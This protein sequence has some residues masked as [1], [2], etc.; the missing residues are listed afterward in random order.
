MAN[1][2]GL[3]ALLAAV[4]VAAH[5]DLVVQL[6]AGRIRGAEC[7]SS[8]A[9]HFQGIP[10][11]EPP[12]GKLRFM[13]PKPFKGSLGKGTFDA[14]KP[15]HPCIQWPSTYDVDDPTP[16]EDCLYLDVYVPA[17]VPSYGGLPV[18]V[19]AHG[20]GND[21]GS[22]SYPLYDSCHLA[23]DAIIV[24][25]QYRLGPL[26]FLGLASAGIQG[27]MAIQDYVA[28]LEWV[29]SNIHSFGGDPSK[30]VLFGQSS[31]ADDA[32]VVSTLP[33]I[34]SLVSGVILE[35]GGGQEMIN[36]AIV[37][38]TGASFAQ[39]LNCK[40][41][42]L[43]CL[44]SKS[45]VEL[46]EAYKKTPALLN[47]LENG[48]EL[49]SAFG[50]DLPNKTT[51]DAS[52]V[53]G[54]VIKQNPLKVGSKVPIIAGMAAAD[55]ALSVLPFF[56]GTGQITEANYTYF[57]DQFGVVGPAIGKQYPLSLFNSSGSTTYAVLAAISH[58][59]T[60]ATYQCSSSRALRAAVAAGTPAYA[61]RFNHTPSCPWL[62]NDGQ[63]FPGPQLASL[64][65]A[66][67][68]SELPF[69]FANLDNQPWGNGTCNATASER[70]LSYGLTSAW[71]AMA[72]KG[73]PSTSSKA[74]PKFDAQQTE[75]IYIQDSMKASKLD[76]SEC[77]FWDEIWAQLGG[78]S[79]P[80]HRRSL[81]NM[82]SPTKHFLQ[83]KHIV[84]AGGGLAGLAFSI[85]LVKQWPIQEAT[86]HITV[87]D[88]DSRY[89]SI[90]RQGYSLSMNGVDADGG[91]VA[92][93]QLG[94][95][96]QAIAKATPGTDEMSFKMWDGNWTELRTIKS[97]PYGSLP[98]GLLR[99]PRRDLREILVGAAE[100]L[101]IDMRWDAQCTTAKVLESGKVEISIL[102]NEKTEVSDKI[103]D[104]LI[105]ADGAQS[106]IRQSIRPDDVLQYAHAT[107]IGGVAKFTDGIPGPAKESWGILISGKGNSCFF[108]PLE[109]N[110]VIWAMSLVEDEPR[111]VPKEL[112]EN[113]VQGLIEE[114]LRH[115]G[116]IAEPFATIVKA[117]DPTTAFIIPAKDKQPF[118]HNDVPSGIIFIGDSNH[119]V[120]PFAGN[121]ANTALKDG[122][123]LAE[124][125]CLSESLADA[126][127][128]YDKASL[129]RAFKTL[130]SSHWRIS[131]AHCSGVKFSL[132]KGFLA[133]TGLC[134]LEPGFVPLL[135]SS[136]LLHSHSS[137]DVTSDMD[138][139]VDAPTPESSPRDFG[140]SHVLH[141]RPDHPHTHTA[142]VL[143]GRGSGAEE[144]AEEFLSSTVTGG[145]SLKDVLP[146]WRWVFP[147]SKETWSPVFEEYMPS[148]FE[149]YSL[150]DITAK[151]KLQMDGIRESVDCIQGILNE[152]IIKLGGKH[153]H[154][155][156]GGIS[157]GAAVG[158]WTLLCQ[159]N[160]ATNL[161][162]F[163]GSSTWIP[164]SG[165]IERTVPSLL[166]GVE[167]VGSDGETLIFDSF[168]EMMMAPRL[169]SLRR[170]P[171]TPSTPVLMGH[172][173]DDAY[174]D[175]ELG[176]RAAAILTQVGYDVD[177]R[178]YSGAEQEGHWF[179]VPQQMDHVSEFLQRVACRKP[180]VASGCY[181]SV[182][183][184]PWT[185]QQTFHS[186]ATIANSQTQNTDTQTTIPNNRDLEPWLY[187]IAPELDL[188]IPFAA[189]RS[190]SSDGDLL[191]ARIAGTAKPSLASPPTWGRPCLLASVAVPMKRSCSSDAPR[192]LP[193]LD[194]SIARRWRSSSVAL[195][196]HHR[197]P[198]GSDIMRRGEG[199]PRNRLSTH[200]NKA[201]AMRSPSAEV[202]ASWPP[203]N[204]D[205]PENRGP[206]LLIVELTVMSIAV[207]TLLARLYVRLFR[208]NKGGLDDLLM[209]AA[210][211]CGVG[212]TICVI[213]ASQ[214]YGWSIH[215]WD[216]T[217]SQATKGRQVSIAGQT[218]F[219][220]ASGLAKDSI[221][222]SYLRIAPKNSWFRRLTYASIALVTSLIFI[223]LI[224]LWTQC[225]PA[226][227][228]WDLIGSTDCSAEGPP[229]LSQAITTVFT[230]LL[231]C[232]LPVPTLLRLKLPLTQRLALIVLF[233]LG[234]V[235]VFAGCM[236]AYW[237]HHVT[238]ETYDVT[239][240]GFYLWIWTAVEANL[241]VICGCV[242]ALRP[243]FRAKGSTISH[244]SA[245][246]RSGTGPRAT[247]SARKSGMNWTDNLQRGS[248]GVRIEDDHIDV[249]SNQYRH[250]HKDVDSPVSTLE[251]EP[252]EERNLERN[253]DMAG[254]LSR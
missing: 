83:D 237:T 118:S 73:N 51:L 48:G 204:Y 26:G 10:F 46:V 161:G 155:V 108:S 124:K 60:V 59:V 218:L 94:L 49:S 188:E 241:G 31:G 27:N 75:G 185:K 222:V 209:V 228:Y 56:L 18:K 21:G 4:A 162:A 104:I 12:I 96:E 87:Y 211:I 213:L 145:K 147:S 248:K 183:S 143:H 72:V 15:P 243:L 250:G 179:K 86:P 227:A 154:L 39:T 99:I 121:G 165:N 187:A 176:R 111:P 149:A 16:S 244:A 150:S 28:A 64:F 107:Q 81:S 254:P 125:L 53:D 226:D 174:V 34:K 42:D 246:F 200:T 66:T 35:S 168:V 139:H 251:L 63:A 194:V 117:T 112:S 92:L 22:L 19:F 128:A 245:T 61:Y 166:K 116:E 247:P 205:N 129:P 7:A 95:L 234:F 62:W 55:S 115:D 134:S 98:T 190:V 44:Q 164:F 175:I 114:A 100:D 11:A 215:V 20:G 152:E 203:P 197:R 238:D 221:L 79:P 13:P 198:S 30:T 40:K 208:V 239:W 88:R 141:P 97:K 119:A 206:T 82:V 195:R 110:T 148:W 146:G 136:L 184:V 109:E 137:T 47:P 225:L 76:F 89:P 231:V 36:Y 54:K 207:L 130:S 173:V 216:L 232:L 67:H 120:S 201:A 32:F 3:L 122:W 178:E 182:G 240:E 57:L 69:V 193:A 153:K 140:P 242:P 159:P 233:C 219:L 230:D 210:M 229:V 235:V 157:Q 196:S 186:I 23:T 199:V 37:Q 223:F 131:I 202:V 80:S 181:V 236:R 144:F 156:L 90:T 52:F 170:G 14:T 71:T 65:G 160:T 180:S 8:E 192:R 93:Q 38:H 41:I 113:Q 158:L 74:W 224:I 5:S 9:V 177:S 249:E 214:L 212:V 24:L 102:E 105:A 142:V 138:S 50:I 189:R 103:C 132:L 135:P 29:R 1:K 33:Q 220:F 91:L 77:Q 252:W 70:E 172:G 217:A 84:V 17:H 253:D 163:F 78:A 133:R 127:T 43:K 85:A 167:V 25:F 191:R 151:Q 126:V 106:K 2:T 6:S 68:T 58:I 45:A 123:D 171:T 169:E 101:G